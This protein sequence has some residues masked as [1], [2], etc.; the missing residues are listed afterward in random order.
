M[1]THHWSHGG[2]GGGGSGNPV[3]TVEPEPLHCKGSQACF[4]LDGSLTPATS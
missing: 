4:P 2:R 1:V 3:R